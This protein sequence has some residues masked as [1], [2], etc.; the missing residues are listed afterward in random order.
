MDVEQAKADRFQARVRTAD[1]RLDELEASARARNAQAEM[2]AIVRLRQQRNSFQHRLDDAR[3]PPSSPVAAVRREVEDEWR[4]FQR[5]LA[6][7]QYRSAWDEA[8]ERR[9]N[10]HLDELD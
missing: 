1:A 4:D 2:E 7:A 9:F 6:D 10:A 8:R 3:H 5:S